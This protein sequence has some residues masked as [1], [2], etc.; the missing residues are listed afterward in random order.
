MDTH[1][2]DKS[3]NVF[4]MV[5]KYGLVVYTALRSVDLVRGTMPES[6]KTFAVLVVCGLDLAFLAWDNYAAHKAKNASQHTVGVGMIVIDLIGIGLALIADTATV[7]DP[8]GSRQLIMTVALF[9]IPIL[10][11]ANIGALSAIDQMDP[12]RKA[13]ENAALH[14]REWAELRAKHAREIE[15]VSQ[16]THLDLERLSNDQRLKGLQDHFMRSQALVGGGGGGNGQTKAMGTLATEGED[17]PT[18]K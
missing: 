18:P 1:G 17:R 14:Q 9:A 2:Q 11:V 7:I 6:I 16:S 5:I 8:E 15:K 13:V 10:V 4:L 3:N 12:D